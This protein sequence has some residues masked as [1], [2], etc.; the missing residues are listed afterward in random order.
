VGRF[1]LVV[2][3]IVL[4]LAGCSHRTKLAKT[5]ACERARVQALR[6]PAHEVLR[7]DV[8]GDGVPDQVWLVRLRQTW[9]RCGA[10]VVVRARGRTLTRPLRTS[11]DPGVPS[12]NGL[13][14]LRL[15]PLEIVLT[16]EEGA[17]TAVARVFTVRAGRISEI[18]SDTVGGGFPYEGSV[19]HLNA[20]DCQRGLVVA[21]GWFERDS[22]GRSFGFERRFYRVGKSG[23]QLVR[24]EHGTSTS[25]FPQREL[26]EF[27]EPQPF[28]SCMQVRAE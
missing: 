13:A 21:S 26:S 9:A 25:P 17:S 16:L 24:K 19:T 12:L 27:R 11:P 7:G 15:R 18:V 14:A 10:F 5:T 20:I 4:V 2:V 3:A 23:F 1:A 22:S 28:P 8:D 6:E